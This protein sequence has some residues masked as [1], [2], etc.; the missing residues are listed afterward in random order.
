[1]V[2]TI[3]FVFAPK[4]NRKALFLMLHMECMYY[5]NP[6]KYF[7]LPTLVFFFFFQVLNLLLLYHTSTTSIFVVE[8]IVFW[9]RVQLSDKMKLVLVLRTFGKITIHPL[10]SPFL[11]E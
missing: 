10:K 4:M 6:D 9:L 1:M 3:F 11:S 5:V 8:H 7:R 2:V